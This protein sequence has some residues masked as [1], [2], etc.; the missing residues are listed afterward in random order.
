MT[1]MP[2]VGRGSRQQQAMYE[3]RHGAGVGVSAVIITLNEERHLGDCLDSLRWVDEILVV[4]AGSTDRT[5]EIARAAGARLYVREWAGYGPQKNFG[6]QRARGEWVLVVDADER[7][8]VALAEEIRAG[9]AQGTLDRYAAYDVPRHNYFFGQW[10]RWGGAF[11]DRQIRLVRRGKGRYNDLPL[12]EHLLVD[13]T[14]GSL[15]GHLVHVAARTLADRLAK[16]NRYADYGAI[17]TS[18]KRR[19]VHWWD[20]VARPAIIFGKL[21]VLKQGFRDGLAGLVYCGLA[22][23]YEFMKYVK[24]WEAVGGAE[25]SFR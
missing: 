3:R 21:Y 11:P 23:L 2:N 17:E 22:S 9:V 1:G 18:K 15:S 5:T 14:V 19:R 24:V 4:D 6:F 8:S 10:L 16:L 13:G 25:A 7:V 12:H 20:L